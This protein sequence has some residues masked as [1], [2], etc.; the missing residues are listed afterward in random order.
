MTADSLDGMAVFVAV[1]EARNFRVAG[2]RLGVSAS[3][4]SQTLRKVER[5]LGVVL[6]Q[7]TTRSVRLSAAGERLYA[8]VR[9][10]LE[11]VRGTIAALGELSDEPRGALRLYVADAA[12]SFLHGPMLA[13]F[14]ASQPHDRCPGFRGPPAR[15]RGEPVVSRA[16][17]AA[18]ASTRAGRSRHPELASDA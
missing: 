6:V 4:V 16:P 2:E 1:A 8:S 10:A 18:E 7:R 3:A 5:R 15:R 12:E 11:E 14:L 13:G 9:P 17:R